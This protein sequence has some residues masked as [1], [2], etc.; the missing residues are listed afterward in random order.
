M[1]SRNDKA[2]VLSFLGV[3][4]DRRDW[5]YLL[6]LLIPLFVYNLTLKVYSIDSVPGLAP[7]FD[8]MRS[9]AFFN[10]GYALFWIGLFATVRGGGFCAGLWSFSSTRRRCS[11]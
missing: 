8:L 5:V 10:L 6:S 4:L 3:L 1:A 2:N 11:W 9:D 7:N